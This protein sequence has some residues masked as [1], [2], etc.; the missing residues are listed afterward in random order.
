MPYHL[1]ITHD[2][3]TNHL[4][5]TRLRGGTEPRILLAAVTAGRGLFP[6]RAD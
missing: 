1:P 4:V 3:T 2:A 6:G 5:P